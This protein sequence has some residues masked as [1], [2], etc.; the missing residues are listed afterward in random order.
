MALP[1]ARCEE[2][3]PEKPA[4]GAGAGTR[5]EAVAGAGA[6]PI[7]GRWAYNGSVI[8]QYESSLS[9]A[10]VLANQIAVYSSQVEGAVTTG[11]AQHAVGRPAAMAHDAAEEL[12]AAVDAEAVGG[13]RGDGV[14]NL[15][16][17][18]GGNAFVGIDP[19]G[20]RCMGGLSDGGRQ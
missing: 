1:A 18:I 10:A 13:R 2:T 19:R 6:V 12:A 17:K 4:A 15:G 8:F 5:A 20:G 11:K 14:A 3:A 16:G 7:N 9:S